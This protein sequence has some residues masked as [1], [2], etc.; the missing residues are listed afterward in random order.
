M[1]D[2]IASARKYR[3]KSFRDVIGQ[4]SI[5]D[6][7]EKALENDQVSHAMLFCGPHGVGK[8]TCARILAQRIN[9]KNADSSD[10]QHENAFNIFE[11][12]AASNNSVDD[13]R[14]LNEQIRYA[15]QYGKYKVYIIDEVH[16]LS[17]SAFNAFLKTLEEPPKYVIFIL[18]TTEKHKVLPT[19]ISRCQIFDFNRIDTL[20]IR[21]FLADLSKK[22]SIRIPTDALHLIARKAQGALRDALSTFDKVVSFSG[23]KITLENVT[24]VLNILDYETYLNVS[25]TLFDGKITESL[26]S[27]DTI[28]KRGFQSQLFISGLASHFRDL[29]VSKD[30]EANKL[31]DVTEEIKVHYAAQSKLW[32]TSELISAIEIC[33]QARVKYASSVNGRLVIELALM[34]LASIKKG[35]ERKKKLE[36]YIKP[37][38]KIKE[39]AHSD[40]P[41]KKTIPKKNENPPSGIE[42]EQIEEKAKKKKPVTTTKPKG[43]LAFSIQGLLSEE[44]ADETETD[45]S[46]MSKDA[47]SENELI[48]KWNSFV[49][50]QK[51]K[52]NFN[53]Y[54][55][56]TYSE[57]ELISENKI[58]YEFASLTMG[59]SIEDGKEELIQF[60]RKELN[61]HSIEMETYINENK[62]DAL[63]YTPEEK[64]NYFVSKNPLVKRL[65]ENLDLDYDY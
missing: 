12:D 60:L 58:R 34:Q 31:L 47:F 5:T 25:Q 41:Q 19:I 32:E 52:G 62:K 17:T 11:L 9:Q 45:H 27:F 21:D 6:T 33:E 42:Q 7:L 23:K 1:N 65:K 4:K 29:L 63:P 28:L 43:D 53:I 51:D 30:A 38:I 49:K 50:K 36:F 39:E 14:S 55:A 13:I 20:E 61:N 26:L 18:A 35:E 40:V 2:F 24:E 56:L 22:E 37:Q 15:P 57:P 46:E 44:E 64:Y 3:P 48:K 59:R 54:R 8:T 16:M 10:E